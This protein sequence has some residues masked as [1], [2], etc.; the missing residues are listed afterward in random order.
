MMKSWAIWYSA[1]FD[2]IKLEIQNYFQ[3]VI[4]KRVRLYV[5]MRNM[6]NKEERLSK[7]GR[8]LNKQQG[9]TL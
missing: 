8:T 5:K 6:L 1:D 3:N 2:K 7:Q 9:R 4:S